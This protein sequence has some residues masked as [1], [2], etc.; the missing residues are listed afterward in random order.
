MKIL[1]DSVSTGNVTVAHDLFIVVVSLDYN[2]SIKAL[3]TSLTTTRRLQNADY[4]LG[5]ESLTYV[6]IYG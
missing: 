3:I 4:S 2:K 6:Y 1:H 5:Q